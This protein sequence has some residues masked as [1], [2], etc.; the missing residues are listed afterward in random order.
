MKLRCL[1]L[2]AFALIE[3][4]NLWEHRAIGCKQLNAQELTVKAGNQEKPDS[5]KDSGKVDPTDARAAAEKAKKEEREKK[6]RDAARKRGDLTF[7]D[8]KFEIERDGLFDPSMLTD[9]I[10]QFDKKV[11]RIRG[12]ILPTSVFQQKGIKQF[13]LVRDNRECCFGPG[14]M[15]YDCIMIELEEPKTSDFTTRP[16]MVKGKLEI[17]TQTYKYPDG[18]NFAIYKIRASEVKAP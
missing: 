15:L 16:V 2:F 3:C 14:A 5:E 11:I 18:K 6:E 8:L 13:V 9:D 10:K 17:D 4:V 12:Y 1:V 7:D